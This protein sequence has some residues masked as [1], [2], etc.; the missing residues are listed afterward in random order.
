MSWVSMF[1]P[2]KGILDT[3]ILIPCIKFILAI[4]KVLDIMVNVN[5]TTNKIK[6]KLL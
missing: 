2:I 3:R 4:P 6:N 5:R 1:D